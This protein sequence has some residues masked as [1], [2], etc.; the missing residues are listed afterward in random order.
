M[1]ENTFQMTSPMPA[2]ARELFDWHIRPGAF[3]R[4]LPPWEDTRILQECLVEDGAMAILR[5][6][7]GPFHARWT[8]QHEAVVDGKSFRDRQVHGPFASW[9]HDHVFVPQGKESQL[10]DRVSFVLP[11]GPL[12]RLGKGSA[13]DRLERL[14]S[15]RH[16]TTRR[17]L[18]RH[19]S[20]TGA[21]LRVAVSGAS[22][23]VGSAL[24]A[25]LRTGGH[26]VVELVRDQ[27]V[28]RPDQAQWSTEQGI[29]EPEKLVDLDALVHLAGAGIADERWTPERMALLRSS[30]VEATERLLGSIR[31]SVGLPAVV[32]VASAI[33][34]YGDRGDEVLDESSRPGE[35]FLA[36][37]CQDWEAAARDV[38]SDTTRVCSM[39]FGI[40]TTPTGGA[41][42]RML[43]PFKLGGGG[44]V[45]GGRQWMSWVSIDDAV[46]AIFHI[47]THDAMTGPINVCS[48]QPVT[49]R[50]WGKTLGKTLKR[51]AI[52]PLPAFAARAA[53][54]KLADPLL[55]ASQRVSPSGLASSGFEFFDS[56]LGSGLSRL[57]GRYRRERR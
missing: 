5:V 53:F 40:V 41:L 14:F 44:P 52:L 39:R 23:L 11:G 45:G 12:G 18:L 8:A 24:C 32:A 56:E 33:G 54:G 4:L 26:E 34:Y 30:R 27:A 25:F 42:K 29:L 38:A 13:I 10:Q 43:L 49:N 31:E 16:E 46:H 9:V 35:G 20:W 2:S 19:A 3:R 36:E 51:P 57:L 7:I 37:L 1:T 21:P 50:D 15:Y 28:R 55:L 47:L 48:P 22:G 17:D 6:P